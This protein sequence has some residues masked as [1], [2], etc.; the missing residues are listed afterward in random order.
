MTRTQDPFDELAAM[1][2]TGPDEKAK[3]RDGEDTS[4]A[5]MT[6]LLI[7]AHLPVRGGLWLTP[8]ILAKWWD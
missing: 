6:E 7:V 8:S 3:T 4:R 2:L 5:V 1:F